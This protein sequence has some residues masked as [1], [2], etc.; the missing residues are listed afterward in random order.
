MEHGHTA[1]LQF[2]YCSSEL[3]PSLHV[4]LSLLVGLESNRDGVAG[5][6]GVVQYS[7]TVM[8]ANC[9]MLVFL[10]LLVRSTFPLSSEYC[11]RSSTCSHTHTTAHTVIPPY[12]HSHS[13]RPTIK[14]AQK[15]RA[16]NY[17]T[18]PLQLYTL[19]ARYVVPVARRPR[20]SLA[21]A[22]SSSALVR[23]LSERA[24]PR[25]GCSS[26]VALSLPASLRPLPPSSVAWRL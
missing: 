13:C 17:Y 10:S 6:R 16:Y 18:H 4:L 9:L 25:G 20:L 2:S 8:A 11:L 12:S 1:H 24:G 26:P 22:R 23:L 14:C 3:C 21:L 5:W 15:I 7:L 19:R